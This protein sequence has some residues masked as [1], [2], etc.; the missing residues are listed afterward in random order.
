MYSS[1]KKGSPHRNYQSPAPIH[2]YWRR[3]RR[4][5]YQHCCTLINAIFREAALHNKPNLLDYVA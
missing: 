5:T 4:A 3:K 1:I 2:W